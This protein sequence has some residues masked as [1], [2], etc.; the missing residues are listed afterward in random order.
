[1]ETN[2][3]GGREFRRVM[4]GAYLP[5]CI[6]SRGCPTVVLLYIQRRCHEV[7]GCPTVVLLYIQRRCH[8]VGLG[9][10]HLYEE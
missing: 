4:I 10:G 6:S 3:S 9:Q 8:E 5:K 7:G 2:C 1:M